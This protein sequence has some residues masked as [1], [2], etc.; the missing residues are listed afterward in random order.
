MVCKGRQWEVNKVVVCLQSEYFQKQCSGDFKVRI[1][2]LQTLMH[3]VTSTESLVA[4]YYAAGGT[5][6]QD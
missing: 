5:G 6:R 4:K 2:C 3:R 1:Y